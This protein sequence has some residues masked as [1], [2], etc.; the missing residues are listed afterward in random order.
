MKNISLVSVDF[1]KDGCS[2]F[3]FFSHIFYAKK[4][5]CNNGKVTNWISIIFLTALS[6]MFLC[7]FWLLICVLKMSFGHLRNDGALKFYGIWHFKFA[8]KKSC[9]LR[10]QHGQILT[11]QHITTQHNNFIIKAHCAYCRTVPH[12]NIHKERM[13]EHVKEE[14]EERAKSTY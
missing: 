12:L 2:W 5:I 7:W 1:R 10:I 6:H 4:N 9:V 11:M 13:E 8:I 3:L 14:E